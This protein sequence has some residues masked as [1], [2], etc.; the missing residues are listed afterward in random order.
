MEKKIKRF[1]SEL[2]I[3]N[4]KRFN[5]EELENYLLDSYK[6][7]TNYLANGGYVELY[8][9]IDNFKNN[10][11]IKEIRSSD[12]NRLNPP[13]RTRWEIISIK[14]EGSW[15]KSKILQFS[16]RLDFSYYVNNPTYQTDLEWEFIENIYNFLL[17]SEDRQ[18][19]S[20]EERCL[21]LFYDEKFILNRGDTPKG[22]YGILKRLKLEYD[23]LKMKRYGEMFIYWNR[24]T[25]DI[26][27]VIILEN[28][29][30]FFAYKNAAETM[31]NIFGFRPDAIIF[32]EGKKIENSFSFI[33]EIS[34][35]KEL[36]VLYFGDIDP[37]GFGI[38]N[39]LK[40][41]YPDFHIKLQYDAY[42][43]LLD[44]CKRDYPQKAQNK[45]I[46]YLN[47]FLDEMEDY[48]DN[49]KINKLQYIWDNDFR[50]PQ[51]LINYEYLLKV[52]K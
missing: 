34:D 20:V 4:K 29:S 1:L 9:Q 22:K 23:D 5:L 41:R 14:E 3:R 26:K 11:Y 51:E 25:K 10:D 44:S 17:S 13:L 30:T 52:I 36:E 48:L 46:L 42:L 43:H 45:D 37:E 32:G 39:R 6:G 21:E 18:W 35:K 31:G 28:H 8:N 15:D 19:A 12:Y 27:K 38:Y 2:E 16:D 24:G 40:D 47:Y 49:E 7:N 33:G 50:I